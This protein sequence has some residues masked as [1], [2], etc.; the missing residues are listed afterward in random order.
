MDLHEFHEYIPMIFF[1]KVFIITNVGQ[2]K[3]FKSI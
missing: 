3:G 1:Y 2:E